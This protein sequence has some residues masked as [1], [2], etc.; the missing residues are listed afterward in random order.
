MSLPSEAHEVLTYWFAGDDEERKQRWWMKNE[1]TDNAIRRQ[2]GEL[3]A[4]ASGGAFDDWTQTIRG[5]LALILLL[6]QVPR[7]IHRGSPASWASDAKAR[8][9]VRDMV[10]AGRHEELPPGPERMFLLMP[11]VHSERTEDQEESI[12][13][14]SEMQ[15]QQGGS[16]APSWA[17]QH[18]EIVK[19]FGRF[20]HRNNVLGR[21]S[22]QEEEEFLGQPNSSF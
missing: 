8:E 20:P 15:E 18:M 22:T 1:D 5:A 12:R 9:H 2:F 21:Q 6:D 13:L 4:R 7:T 14:C 11:L 17:I 10:A 19:R 3:S 16:G